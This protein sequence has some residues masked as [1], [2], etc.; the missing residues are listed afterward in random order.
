MTGQ[1]QGDEKH[2]YNVRIKEKLLICTATHTAY[3]VCATRGIG[4][5]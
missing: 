3:N 5:I 1:V 2:I 4:R